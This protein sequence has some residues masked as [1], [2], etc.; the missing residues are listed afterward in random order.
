MLYVHYSSIKLGKR[1]REG[2]GEKGRERKKSESSGG[3]QS[4]TFLFHKNL[5]TSERLPLRTEPGG[6]H[7]C[8]PEKNGWTVFSS[9]N[10][11]NPVTASASPPASPSCGGQELL[12]PPQA[13]DVHFWSFHLLLVLKPTRLCVVSTPFFLCLG[14]PT[15][16]WG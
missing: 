1:K 12:S 9:P 7:A 13:L 15:G 16:P 3:G 10:K 11:R 14:F 5:A 6:N 4:L 8:P 2:R